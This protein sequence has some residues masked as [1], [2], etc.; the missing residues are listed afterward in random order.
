MQGYIS[1]I[2]IN[3]NKVIMSLEDVKMK[4]QDAKAFGRTLSENDLVEILIIDYNSSGPFIEVGDKVAV[5]CGYTKDK[6]VLYSFGADI[7]LRN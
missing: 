3:E 2:K 1:N 5:S 6:K 7:G 4:E